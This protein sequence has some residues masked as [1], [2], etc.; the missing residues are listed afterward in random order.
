MLG[1]GGGGFTRCLIAPGPGDWQEKNI[2]DGDDSRWTN[3]TPPVTR[4][5]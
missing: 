4:D 3:L 5:H 1:T 2:K